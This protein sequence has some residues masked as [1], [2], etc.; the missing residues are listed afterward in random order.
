MAFNV[1]AFSLEEEIETQRKIALNNQDTTQYRT[2]NQNKQVVLNNLGK[3]KSKEPISKLQTYEAIKIET[4]QLLI[5]EKTLFII[6]SIVT[7]GLLV[8]TFRI[9]L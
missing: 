6:N 3:L 4:E 8:A 9:I 5:R 2:H 7:V 1:E